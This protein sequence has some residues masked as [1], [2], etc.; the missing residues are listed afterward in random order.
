MLWSLIA[1]AMSRQTSGFMLLVSELFNVSTMLIQKSKFLEFFKKGEEWLWIAYTDPVVN[2]RRGLYF[3]NLL[4]VCSSI[5][6]AQTNKRTILYLWVS[7]DFSVIGNHPRCVWKKQSDIASIIVFSWC[8]PEQA[9]IFSVIV[10]NQYQD[11]G[12]E[13]YCE[14]LNSGNVPTVLLQ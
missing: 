2:I 8:N 4:I 11:R 12:L 5:L 1:I 13:L 14:K 6:K 3:I 10:N 9:F 7:L